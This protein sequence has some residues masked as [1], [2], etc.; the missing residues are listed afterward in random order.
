VEQHRVAPLYGEQHAGNPAAAEVGAN[1][2]E[3]IAHR[4]TG[5]HTDRP[6]KL[7]GSDIVTD[8][9][10]VFGDQ[11]PQPIA[12]RL[13]PGTGLIESGWQPLH[14]SNV[15][16]MVRL[17]NCISIRA[18]EKIQSPDRRRDNVVNKEVFG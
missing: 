13:R 4:T 11:A 10:A 18:V 14:T 7:D 9:F 15:P 16:K 17:G 1:L 5:R 6:A 2:E 3:P 8:G 12:D